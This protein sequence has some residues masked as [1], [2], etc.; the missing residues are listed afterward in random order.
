MA[1][2]IIS[3]LYVAAQILADISSL[4]ILY[5]LGMS[6]DGGTF[7]Y[8]ITFTLRDLLHKV[9]GVK[10]ARAIIIVAAVV[11]ILMAGMFWLVATLPPDE[12]VGPQIAFINALAPVW[13]IVFASIAAEVISEL[14]DTE[15]YRLWVARF[16]EKYQWAR[17]LVSNSVSIPIDSLLFCW[18]AFGGILPAAIVWSIVLSNVV[19]KGIVTLVSIPSIYLVKEK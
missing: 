9:A 19:I 14:L 5:I 1:I 10:V 16:A 17:V 15:A 6:I 3:A 2:A 4:R 8:P 18:I 12:A 7:I 13:R 11:N